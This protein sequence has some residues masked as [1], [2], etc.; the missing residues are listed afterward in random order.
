MI[1]RDITNKPVDIINKKRSPLRLLNPTTFLIINKI[2]MTN[3]K[4][5]NLRMFKIIEFNGRPKKL[6]T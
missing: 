4:A 2:T 5:N 1:N 3:A 6:N